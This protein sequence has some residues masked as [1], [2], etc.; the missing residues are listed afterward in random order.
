MTATP[1]QRTGRT[2]Q[3]YL[4]LNIYFNN[5]GEASVIESGRLLGTGTA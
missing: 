1:G 4:Y 5:K 3:Y 2:G